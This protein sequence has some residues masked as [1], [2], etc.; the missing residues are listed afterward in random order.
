MYILKLGELSL[1]IT[2]D[3]DLKETA[4]RILEY[5]KQQPQKC[6]RLKVEGCAYSLLKLLIEDHALKDY[7]SLR[8]ALDILK[9]VAIVCK[10]DNSDSTQLDQEFFIL[11][12]LLSKYSLL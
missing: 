7:S 8:N 6:R 1:P 5:E 2:Y 10:V 4:I 12:T 11:E 9:T 3:T